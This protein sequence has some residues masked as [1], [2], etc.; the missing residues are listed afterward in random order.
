M[1][2]SISPYM[3]DVDN[4][5]DKNFL[6]FMYIAGTRARTLIYVVAS[7]EFWNYHNN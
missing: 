2:T 7:E 3:G 1:V 5:S 6:R 4:I